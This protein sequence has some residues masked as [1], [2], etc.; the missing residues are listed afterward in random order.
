M[1]T[2]SLSAGGAERSVVLLSEGFLRR[3]HDVNIVTLSASAADSF[4]LP[5]GVARQ[6]LDV[7]ADSRFFVQGLWRNLSRLAAVRKAIRATRPDIVISHQTETNVLTQLALAN[8]GYPVV[9]VEHSD[10]ATNTRR[11]IWRM[12]RRAVYP[13]AAALVSVSRSISD[14]FKWLPESKKAVIPNPVRTIEAEISAGENRTGRG[15]KQKWVAA[16][17]RLIP[18]KGFDRLLAAFAD[19]AEKHAD[20]QLVILGEGK[21]RTDLEQ[22]I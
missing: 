3:Q 16:M 9:L 13:R 21:L 2:P 8:T 12:L 1:V 10:P 7:A 4:N 18:V 17:G 19:L 6:S 14:C 22:Q 15:T 11:R 20:W 5:Q